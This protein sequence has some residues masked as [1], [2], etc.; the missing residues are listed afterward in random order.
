MGWV[1]TFQ[2]Q[3]VRRREEKGNKLKHSSNDRANKGFEYYQF[4]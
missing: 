3:K 2:S 1:W 4:L